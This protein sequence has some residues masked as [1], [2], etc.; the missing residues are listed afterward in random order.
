MAN[1]PL[2]IVEDLKSVLEDPEI[3]LDEPNPHFMG[4]TPRE[5][6]GTEREISLRNWIRRVKHGVPS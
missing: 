5:L 6:I 2:D 4:R 3:W 1:E